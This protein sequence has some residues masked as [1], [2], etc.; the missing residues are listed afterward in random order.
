[1]T[2]HEGMASTA[3]ITLRKRSGVA[4]GPEG[5]VPIVYWVGEGFIE[6][7]EG[8]GPTEVTRRYT[9]R[10]AL[11][12]ALTEVVVCDVCQERPALVT[13]GCVDYCAPCAPEEWRQL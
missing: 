7:E 10:K 5:P 8:L 11:L 13:L 3:G 1:M 9:T 2:Y 6:G 12:L 4:A